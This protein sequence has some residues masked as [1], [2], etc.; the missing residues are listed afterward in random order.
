MHAA[1]G[2]WPAARRAL[3]EPPSTATWRAA[4]HIRSNPMVS[5]GMAITASPSS[6]RDAVLC[7]AAG[8]GSLVG[9]VLSRPEDCTPPTP[10]G[11]VTADVGT[12]GVKVGWGAAAEPG[13]LYKVYCARAGEPYRVPLR[14]TGVTEAS[15]GTLPAG[16]YVAWVT[17]TDASGNESR[18]TATLDVLVP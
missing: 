14:V 8:D 17:A 16:K 9:P 11:P 1:G 15:L 6:P 7:V 2:N 3:H 10:P 13:V 18:R 12:G 4:V 5:A